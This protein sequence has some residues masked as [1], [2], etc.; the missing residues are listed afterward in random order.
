MALENIDSIMGIGTKEE[1]EELEDIIVR[2]DEE[3]TNAIANGLQDSLGQDKVNKLIQEYQVEASRA[4]QSLSGWI[5]SNFP[6]L[7]TEA[8][9]NVRRELNRET[10]EKTILFE[11]EAHRQNVDSLM[12]IAHEDMT[13]FVSNTNRGV[14]ITLNSVLQEQQTLRMAKGLRP[15]GAIKIAQDK[16][17]ENFAATK[18]ITENNFK[19]VFSK[20]GRQMRMIPYAKMLART[21]MVKTLAEGQKASALEQD[22]DLVEWITNDPCEQCQKYANQVFSITGQSDKYPQL[23]DIPVH[24]NCECSISPRIDLVV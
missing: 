1:F 13:N 3:A 23:P 4:Q 8:A 18:Q 15:S 2:L 14:K 20:S 16:V 19:I 6:N 5:S 24:P 11:N 12:K 9:N 7:Y 17:I 22:V 10:V 21:N